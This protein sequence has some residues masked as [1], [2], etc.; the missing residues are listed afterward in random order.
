MAKWQEVYKIG[1]DGTRTYAGGVKYQEDGKIQYT[2]KSRYGSTMQLGA[3]NAKRNDTTRKAREQANGKKNQRYSR[4][5][6]R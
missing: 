2:Q 6:G 5:T 1:M 3:A 4:T